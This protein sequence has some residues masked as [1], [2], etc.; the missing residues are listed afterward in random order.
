MSLSAGLGTFLNVSEQNIWV[1]FYVWYIFKLEHNRRTLRRW[2][3]LVSLKTEEPKGKEYNKM[4]CII[5]SICLPLP[6]HNIDNL[7]K[8][9]VICDFNLLASMRPLKG[10]LLILLSPLYIE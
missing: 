10:P 8:H 9:A 3:I 1:L 7:R 6:I 2:Y 4:S 5:L